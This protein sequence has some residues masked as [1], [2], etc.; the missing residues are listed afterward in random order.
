MP[1]QK[2]KTKQKEQHFWSKKP[3][4]KIP[5]D[6]HF[7]IMTDHCHIIYGEVGNSQIKI[8]EQFW[9]KTKH[10]DWLKEVELKRRRVWKKNLIAKIYLLIKNLYEFF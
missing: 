1:K 8:S 2:T 6:Y 3:Q 7:I 9:I 4:L 5:S 10:S